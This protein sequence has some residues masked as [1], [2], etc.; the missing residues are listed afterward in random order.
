MTSTRRA[1][2]GTWS[3][4]RPNRLR[5]VGR[6]AFLA[7]ACGY[8]A[9]SY[10]ALPLFLNMKLYTQGL[11]RTPY[12][13]RV[14]P[15][16]VFRTLTQNR[17]F[18]EAAAHL[19]PIYDDSY[20]LVLTLMAFVCLAVAVLATSATLRR[21]TGDPTFAF[22]SAFLV[23]LWAQLDLAYAWDNPFTTPY[24]V[25]S[26]M[27]FALGIAFVVRRSWWAYYP[28]FVLAVFN[29]ETACFITVFLAVWEWLRLRDEGLAPRA[30]TL[31]IAP[32]VACQ[33]AIWVLIKIWLA[34]SFAHNPTEQGGVANGL[35]ITHF[36]YNLRELL[37]PQQWPLLASVCGFSLPFLW[38]QRRWIGV[39]GLECAII[40]ILPLSFAGLMVV[41]RVVEIRIFADWIALVAPAVAMIFRNRFHLV[42]TLPGERQCTTPVEAATAA[43]RAASSSQEGSRLL[44]P[45]RAGQPPEARG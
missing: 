14:L 1:G 25:P 42:R 21:L 20:R 23:I 18:S 24:D 5:F 36:A 8:F 33:A 26:L 11:E 43:E 40:V 44:V 17:L 35:F 15:M 28:S 29:R 34:R 45:E 9:L 27:F 39:P 4:G 19:P 16:L 37:K 6:W 22:W 38:L 12:Q 2:S 13:Y 31:R 41:G 32:H 7:V 10:A 30:R 3:G